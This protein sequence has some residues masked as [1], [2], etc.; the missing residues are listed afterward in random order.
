MK[1]VFVI[2]I[3]IIFFNTIVSAQEKRADS[4]KINLNKNS[5]NLSYGIAQVYFSY[6]RVFQGKVFGSSN[7]S[8]VD[9]G[10]GGVAY[11]EGA[12]PYVISRFGILTGRGSRHFEAK[13]GV[14]GIFGPDMEGVLP[15]GAIGYRKQK[16][17]SNF[18]FRT[19][20][21]F[22]DLLY[23]SWGVSF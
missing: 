19:G 21:G 23:V 8:I 14:F 18:I 1:N 11:W 6:E 7:S 2:S 20:I 10:L 13:L 12:S 16:P 9:F 22:P 4:L 3:L 17:G 5:I 15:S